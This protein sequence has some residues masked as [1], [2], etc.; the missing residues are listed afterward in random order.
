[1]PHIFQCFHHDFSHFLQLASSGNL[2]RTRY[3]QGMVLLQLANAPRTRTTALC[4][5]VNDSEVPPSARGQTS[6]PFLHGP[7]AT[8]IVTVPS[9]KGTWNKELFGSSLYHRV[10]KDR[11][12]VFAPGSST[13]FDKIGKA[14]FARLQRRGNGLVVITV[15][16]I[17]C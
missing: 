10:C 14:G 5:N 4:S 17:G 7:I 16:S 12:R 15:F 6:A 8:A 9:V 2:P 11:S 13:P 3:H 1:M